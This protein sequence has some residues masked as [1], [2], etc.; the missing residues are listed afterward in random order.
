M[1]EKIY[2]DWNNDSLFWSAG[3]VD[4]VWSEVFIIIGVASA[5][6]TGGYMPEED[7]WT[8]LDK[9]LDKKVSDEFKKI[10]I[11]VN[12]LTK[13]KELGKNQKITVD[14]IKKTLDHFGFGNVVRVRMKDEDE[15]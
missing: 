3:P 6:E 8:W 15:E 5:V 9:K 7:P 13:V 2:L 12:G 4:Y 11:R 1:S 14:H 10:M